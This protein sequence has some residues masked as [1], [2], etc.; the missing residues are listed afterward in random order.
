MR[1]CGSTDVS[2]CSGDMISTQATIAAGSVAD[3]TTTQ[4]TV[5]QATTPIDF[6]TTTSSTG[7]AAL[8]RADP[9]SS[10]HTYSLFFVCVWSS[11]FVASFL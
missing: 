10:G 9:V 8:F 6:T 1:G 11:I 5:S 3:A 4:A 7:S 2:T